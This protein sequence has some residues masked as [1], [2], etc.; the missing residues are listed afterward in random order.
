[1]KAECREPPEDNTAALGPSAP[2]GQEGRA[3]RGPKNPER[4]NSVPGRQQPS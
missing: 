3:L 4:K 1:M 2:Q